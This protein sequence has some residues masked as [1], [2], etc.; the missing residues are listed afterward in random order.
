MPPAV[1]P[2]SLITFAISKVW[3]RSTAIDIKCGDIS[4]IESN[5]KSLLYQGTF[6]KAEIEILYKIIDEGGLGL[7]KI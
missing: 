1:P 2:K 4:Q 7:T 5:L 6:E 3:Y